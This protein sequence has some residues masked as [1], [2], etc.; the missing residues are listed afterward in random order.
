LETVR[1]VAFLCLLIYFAKVTN[2]VLGSI[3]LDIVGDDLKSEKAWCIV[4]KEE[5]YRN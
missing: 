5:R 1:V 4:N 2:P 3:F